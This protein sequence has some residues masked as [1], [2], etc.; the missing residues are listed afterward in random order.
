VYADGHL[1]YNR[2]GTLLARPFDAAA[3]TFTGDAI[4]VAEAISREG[5]RYASFSVSETGTLVYAVGEIRQDT[6][7]SLFDREG[8]RLRTVGRSGSNGTIALSPDE[9]RVALSATRNLPGNDDIYL[10]DI[11]TGREDR[12]TFDPAP[13][14]APVWSS[15]GDWVFFTSTRPA[16]TGRS[17][18]AGV[19][20]LMRKAADNSRPE[21]LLL[22]AAVGSGNIVPLAP[23]PDERHLMVN[24]VEEGS[25]RD[26]SILALAGD[27][28]LRRFVQTPA[29]DVD[30]TF[31]ADGNLV[32]YQSLEGGR[33][34]VFVEAFP[35]G[36]QRR[37]ITS[38]GGSNPYWR[39]DGRELF[40]VDLA[41]H[42]IAVDTDTRGGLRLGTPK[43]LFAVRLRPGA[44]G[45]QFV[46][47]RD[48]QRI[49]VNELEGHAGTSPVH[50]LLNWLEAVRR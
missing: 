40:W 20:V 22:E 35:A 33:Y 30:A 48:G 4:V 23:S 2:D 19:P 39:A 9:R 17:T 50:V 16:R 41:G 3:R 13:D 47:T 6:Q 29:E 8:Q 49:L 36:G 21:E 46:V 26:L 12:F 37:Q 27:R 32:A 10:L 45:R 1:L 11:E 7:L 43:E 34:Q 31:S 14:R 44:D 28:T 24:R 25:L 15:K 18:G 42:L 38:D 5:S